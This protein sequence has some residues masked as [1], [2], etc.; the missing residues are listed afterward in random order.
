MVLP[1]SWPSQAIPATTGS[2]P[3]IISGFGPNLATILGASR[4]VANS[5]AV[6]GTKATPAASGVKPS[7]SWT[8]WVRKKNDP[9]MPATS[10]SRA[11]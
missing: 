1:D 7:T 9:N 11:R 8:N 10:S 2:S 4:E 5:A 3:A 6:I